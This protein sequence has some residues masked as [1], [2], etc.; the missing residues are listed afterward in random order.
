MITTDLFTYEKETKTLVAMASTGQL[1]DLFRPGQAVPSSFDV[2]STH[3][4]RVIRFSNT[5]CRYDK[6]GDLI[7]WKYTSTE[8][9]VKV[10]IF[11]D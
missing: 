4:G 10:I 6:E 5:K 9:D 1:Y 11:N 3:T 2:R 7:S 8:T